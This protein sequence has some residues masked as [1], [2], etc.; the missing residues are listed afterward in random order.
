MK[1]YGAVGPHFLHLGTT[2]GTQWIGVWVDP[3][4]GLDN[5]ENRK[6]LTLPGLELRTLSRPARIQSLYQLRYLGSLIFRHVKYSPI[7]TWWYIKQWLWI[8]TFECED[9]WFMLAFVWSDGS[10][11]WNSSIKTFGRSVG[12]WMGTTAIWSQ[13]QKRWRVWQVETSHTVLCVLV[14][15]WSWDWLS[16]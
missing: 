9:R 11:R 12:S 13:Q 5:L 3:G 2:W 15:P 7:I 14:K 16:M 8:V 6:F 4:V 1:A 10:K